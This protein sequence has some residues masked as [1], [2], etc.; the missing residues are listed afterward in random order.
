M[1][2]V[3][4]VHLNGRNLGGLIPEQFSLYLFG[5]RTFK[6][7]T[8]TTTTTTTPPPRGGG[9]EKLLSQFRYSRSPENHFREVVVYVES[10]FPIGSVLYSLTNEEF[11]SLARD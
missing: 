10:L 5:H 6:G 7:T 8:T 2:V 11:T 4:T 9:V 3:Y 1:Y